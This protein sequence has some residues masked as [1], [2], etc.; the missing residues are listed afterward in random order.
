M[1]HG[2]R[3]EGDI[4]HRASD[5]TSVDCVNRSLDAAADHQHSSSRRKNMKT[6]FKILNFL[7]INSLQIEKNINFT[8]HLRNK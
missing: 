4:I 3:V 5:V 7:R 1:N 8:M 2:T 6:T